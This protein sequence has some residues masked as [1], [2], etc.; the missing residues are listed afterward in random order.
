VQTRTG[1]ESESL[2]FEALLECRRSRCEGEVVGGE[3][4]TRRSTVILIAMVGG[5][6]HEAL[7]RSFGGGGE[8]IYHFGM[9]ARKEQTGT[10]S[11]GG[12]GNVLRNEGDNSETVVVAGNLLNRAQRI[13]IGVWSLL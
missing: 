8:R 9:Q 10:R 11:A 12:T 7:V 5:R 6:V 4:R 1:E 2:I 3:R 13:R